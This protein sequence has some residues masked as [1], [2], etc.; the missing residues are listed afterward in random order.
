MGGWDKW[1]DGWMDGW[2]EE[3]MD[4]WMDELMD[5]KTHDQDRKVILQAPNQLPGR[6]TWIMEPEGRSAE[7]CF[8]SFCSASYR[9][10]FVTTVMV[11]WFYF[12]LNFSHI[13]Y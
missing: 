2:M 6:V 13:K 3:W 10:S 8:M 12:T 4:G 1:M 7:M 11:L 9:N 5:G